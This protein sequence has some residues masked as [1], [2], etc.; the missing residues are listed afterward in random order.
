MAEEEKQ[1]VREF[2]KEMEENG[3]EHR[4]YIKGYMS[5]VKEERQREAAGK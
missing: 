5:G 1:E 2:L 3:R 4:A